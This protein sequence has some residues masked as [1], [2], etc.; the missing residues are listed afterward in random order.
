MEITTKRD[1]SIDILRAFCTLFIMLAH[2]DI[3]ELL[4]NIR[5]FDVTV[6]ILI[7]GISMGY[8]SKKYNLTYGGYIWK[9]VQKLLIPT[10]MV[11]T[12]IFITIFLF[13][14]VLK[15]EFLWNFNQ[16]FLS[17]ALI[18]NGS[19]IGYGWIVRIF[20]MIALLQPI[21]KLFNKKI[22]NNLLFLF[23]VFLAFIL[24][25]LLFMYDKSSPNIIISYLLIYL[26][27]YGLVASIGL[28]IAHDSKFVDMALI[29]SCITFLICQV[30]ISINGNGFEPNFFKYPPKL[31]YITYGLL[32]GILS[33]KLLQKIQ[34]NSQSKFIVSVNW[35]SKNSFKVY[36][37]HIF[38]LFGLLV[39]RGLFSEVYILNNFIVQF[40]LVS[41]SAVIVTVI[42]N[43]IR[44]Y[45]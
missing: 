30:L 26:I 44:L 38:S 4:L 23:I 11:I 41:S 20:L 8:E 36:L 40:I 31:Y 42:F 7:S 27:P 33:Y 16:V 25:E 1:Q 5:T 22:K 37:F 12:T 19:A 2:V 28:R 9:R 35:L 45:K 29:V 43:K 17:Y 39:L 24:N 32:V 21:L 15:K 10:Y 14:L 13:S 18:P 6:L 34:W 3:P